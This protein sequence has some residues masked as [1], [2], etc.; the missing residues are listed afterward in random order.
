M[1]KDTNIAYIKSLSNKLSYIDE[2]GL[3]SKDILSL[4]QSNS[5]FKGLFDNAIKT[6]K[7]I[8]LNKGYVDSLIN[9]IAL[10]QLYKEAIESKDLE[11]LNK[12][13]INNRVIKIISGIYVGKN[14]AVMQLISAAY[15]GE[16]EYIQEFLSN[17]PDYFDKYKEFLEN[18][19]GVS[20]HKNPVS[21]IAGQFQLL[22]CIKENDATKLE[23][24]IKERRVAFTEN[25]ITNPEIEGTEVATVLQYFNGLNDSL[26][27]Q[28][29]QDE[30]NI[31]IIKNLLSK[32]A[33]PEQSYSSNDN[34]SA[35]YIAALNNKI[36]VLKI[37]LEHDCNPNL[38]NADDYVDDS[39][40]HAA[41]ARGHIDIIKQLVS[42]GADINITNNNGSLLHELFEDITE[43]SNEFKKLF[44]DLLELGVDPNIQNKY[45]KTV[46]YSIVEEADNKIVSQNIMYLIEV[47]AKHGIKYEIK[48]LNNNAAMD[49]DKAGFLRLFIPI[50]IEAIRRE[51]LENQKKGQKRKI[52]VSEDEPS[53]KR[54]KYEEKSNSSSS[55]RSPIYK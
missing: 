4:M 48:D 54:T 21:V 44:N 9:H 35:I 36:E 23:H 50:K 25:N 37:F 53:S 52:E 20:S 8:I 43:D 47:L 42:N 14:N 39:L 15:Y 18:Y 13:P 17:N 24:L 16:I 29:S 51:Q 10:I 11:K 2:Q 7:E 12:L 33:N 1:S 46:L 3:S 45:G 55:D 30:F 41:I 6:A 26:I 19:K 31:D 27:A 34:H 32:G 5:Q 40:L 28:L 38:K 49:Y 22:K